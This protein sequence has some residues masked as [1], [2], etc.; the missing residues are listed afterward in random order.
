MK[1]IVLPCLAAIALVVGPMFL[2][3]A[4][5]ETIVLVFD[6]LPE[7]DP[8]P[9]AAT[10]EVD[11]FDPALGTLTSVGFELSRSGEVTVAVVNFLDEPLPVVLTAA[12]DAVLIGPD[13][14]VLLDG[15][16]DGSVPFILSPFDPDADPT[17]IDIPVSAV[18]SSTDPPLAVDLDLFTAS[19]PGVPETVTLTES[20]PDFLFDIDEPVEVFSALA[21]VSG[22]SLTVTY[23]F[24]AL[25]IPE[26]SSIVLLGLGTVG[27]W[28]YARRRR[29]RARNRP[30]I[31]K[32][33]AWQ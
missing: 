26:P 28:G 17:E 24:D 22:S 13:D 5:A 9:G 27:L 6:P 15:S 3:S 12:I 4:S 11:A 33:N 18:L 29:R 20:Y 7:V 2:R 30:V 32:P 14:V 16:L 31:D 10:I 19:A 25:V 21:S 8:V 1:K 23:T